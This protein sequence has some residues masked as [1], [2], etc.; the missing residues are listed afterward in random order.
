MANRSTPSVAGWVV[1]TVAFALASPGALTAPLPGGTL[2]PTSIPKYVVPLVIPPA[3][4]KSP[5]TSPYNQ[6][7]VTDYNIAER[8]FR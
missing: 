7:V 3:M 5:G 2:V 8:Q 1:S 6:G 4:P